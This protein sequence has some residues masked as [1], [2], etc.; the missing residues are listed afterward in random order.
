MTAMFSS[1]EALA[2]VASDLSSSLAT[3]DRYERLL[4]AVR[5]AVPCDAACLMAL[6]G[7]EL[8]P[9]A[10]HGLLPQAMR[11]RYPRR[12]HPR[13]DAILANPQ[14]IQFPANSTLPDPFD[15]NLQV[16]PHALHG[17]HA[18]LGCA[19]R[20]GDAVVGAL[21]ADALEPRAFDHLDPQ[22]LRLLAGLAGAALR[23]A[24]MIEIL[25][26]T[27]DRQAQDLRDRARDA[28]RSGFLGVSA[29]AQRVLEDV[30]LVAATDLPVLISGETGVGKELVAAMVHAG[31]PRRERPLVI[32]NCAA[33]PE[34]LAESELF[35]HL[36]G[37]FTGATHDR[38][39]KFELADRAT[40]FLDEIGELPVQL[41]AKLLRALQQGEVQRVGSDRSHR[42]DVRVVA[43]TNR[44]LE[45]EIA[46][47]R[48]RADLYHRLA[49]YPIAVPPLRSR[50]EDL[51]ILADHLLTQHRRKIGCPTPVLGA[52]SLDLLKRYPWP[53]NVRELDN[54]LA[55]SI[56][57]AL[58]EQQDGRQLEILPR[59]LSPDLEVRS[60]F[61]VVVRERALSPLVPR[62]LADQV[63]DF[64]KQVIARTVK[65]QKG[66]W[67]A[68][69]RSLGM[70][71]ANLHAIAK[72]LGLK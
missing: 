60:E 18:C 12:Q 20:D 57:R 17:I 68:A 2:D 25:E 19:L 49:T 31:S 56:L 65:S 26:T 72:R 14:P 54:V 40:I 7:D 43:A 27:V 58:G 9:L 15:G 61:P 10:A 64:Q 21:T 33:L 4:E 70:H 47:G 51:S 44:N 55:R 23:T 24:R 30:R 1:L 38:A 67:A 32:V 8:V 69:A 6:E 46:A 35:G 36:A 71:R 59:H 39:G 16:D 37:A 63:D 29:G 62:P 48:F 22:L 53:G 42:V 52:A 34:S 3:R 5:Q 41:Q 66:N 28:Y 13:L 45:A 11:I 50:L